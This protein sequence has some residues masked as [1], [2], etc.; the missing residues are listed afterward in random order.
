M[1]KLYDSTDFKLVESWVTDVGFKFL[2]DRNKTMA[3]H[4]W[5]IQL[6]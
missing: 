5:C 3:Q 2:P 4:Y 1:I 6:G